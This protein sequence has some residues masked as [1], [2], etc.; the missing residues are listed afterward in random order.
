M[1]LPTERTVTG[2]YTNPVTGEPYDGTNGD[3]Y[4]IFEPVPARWTDKFGNQILVG[5]GKVTLEVDGTFAETLVCTDADGVEPEDGRLWKFRQFVA[6]VWRTEYFFLPTGDGTDVDITDILSVDIN[7]IPYV[8]V[9]GGEGPEGPAGPTGPQGPTGATG[10]QGPMGEPGTGDGLT[11]GIVTGGRIDIAVGNPSAITIQPFQ[12]HIVDIDTVPITVTEVTLSAPLTVALDGAALS[13]V[14]T[15]WLI[16]ANLNVYQQELRPEGGELRN[17]I[18][19]GVTAQASGTIILIKSVATLLPQVGNQLV[20]LMDAIG[21]FNILGNEITPNGANKFLNRAAGKVFSRG[22]GHYIG[23]TLTESP[24]TLPTVAETPAT[25]IHITRNTSILSAP[26]TATVDTANYDNNGTLTAIG[27]GANSSVV[28][29]LWLF[30][31]N[32]GG[33]FE[34]HALQYGQTVHPNLADAINAAGKGAYVTNTGLPGNGILLG[35]L[36]VKKNATNLSDP[37]QAN[38]IQAAK[39]GVG[40]GSS[41]DPLTLYAKLAGDTFTGAIGSSLG[42]ASS[43]AHFIQVAGDAFNRYRALADGTML[44]GPG[45]G[46]LDTELSR[47][48]SG[49]MGFVNTDL[50]IGQEAAKAIRVRQSGLDLDI[51]GAAGDLNLSVYELGGFT[52]TLFPYLQLENATQ[53]A[54]AIGRWEFTNAPSNPPVHTIDGASNLLG[55]HGATAIAKQEI[56]G[57]RSTGTALADLLTSLANLGLI[58]DSTTAGPG[59]FLQAANNLS[60]LTDVPTARTN[61]GLGTMATQ[62]MP[63]DIFDVTSYGAVGDGK[64][65]SDG[66]MTAGSATLTCASGPFLPGDVGK[67]VIVLNAGALNETFSGTI[68]AYVS[69]TQVTLS[70]I[71]GSTVSN[72][73]VLWAT[74]DTQEIQ[75]AVNAA[76][77]WAISNSYAATVRF[78]TTSGAFYGVAG[79]LDTSG[80][81]NSQIRLPVVPATGRK[82]TLTFEGERT[83]AGVQHWQQTEINASGAT[84]VSFG[85]FANSTAQLNSINANGNAAVIGGPSQPGGF[86]VAPGVFSNVYFDIGNM[87]ILTCHSK[88]GYTY[89]ALDLSGIANAQL[90]DF[91]YATSGTVAPPGASYQNPSVFASG[92]AVGVALPANGN[93]DNTIVRNVTCGGGYTYGMIATEHTDIFGLR[94]LYCWAALCPAGTY[95]GSVGAAHSIRGTLISIEVC[96]YLIYIFGQGSGGVGP[97]MY[98]HIDTETSTPRFGGTSSGSLAAARGEV[99]LAGLFT[100]SGL[101]LDNPT[102]L[103]I[104]NSQLTF[105]S[106]L[107]TANYTATSFDEVVLGDATSASITISLPTAVGRTDPITVKKV[108]FSQNFVTVD[109]FGSQ[110]IDGVLTVALRV[111]WE[112][113]TVVPHNGNWYTQAYVIT[114]GGGVTIA[115][116]TSTIPFTIAHRG[117]GGEFPEHTMAAYEGAVAAGAMAI[118][119]SVQVTADGVPVCYHDT[120]LMRMSGVPTEGVGDYTYAQLSQVIKVRAQAL[121]GD[122]WSDQPLPT[123]SDVLDR[124]VGKVVIF[125]E[126]KDNDSIPIL[127]D[128]LLGRYPGSQSSV[129]WKNY[130]LS[131]SFAWAKANGFTTWAYID[132]GTTSGQMDSVDANV[133]W[134]GVPL[135]ATDSKITEVVNRGKTVIVWSI[136]RHAD[137]ARV[138]GLGVEGLMEGEWIYLNNQRSM[139]GVQAWTKVKTPGTIGVVPYNADYALKYDSSQRMFITQIPNNAVLMGGHRVSTAQ[140]AGTY[141]IAF[142]MTWDTVPGTATLHSGIAFG[143]PDDTAYIFSGA[144]ASGG[145][146]VV[147]RANGDLQLFRH[148]AGVTTGTQLGSTVPTAAPVAG[149]PMTFEVTVT[150]TALSV[151][152]TDVGPYTVNS[153][154][155]TY[156][157]RYWHLSP[158]SVTDPATTPYFSNVY[159]F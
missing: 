43:I 36:A 139:P 6:G 7:D 131:G 22:W 133:D 124:F 34:T 1:P 17:F 138:T 98:L 27:G 89:S 121:L 42:D 94:I 31:T 127:Q 21:A 38:F 155:T 25:W 149:V 132:T 103:R 71:A 144:N 55:F 4:V 77:L 101:T 63:P 11:T 76:V 24:H 73:P 26:P 157:G 16:D 61:L 3:H 118:E 95:F 54:H 28:H 39:F 86:G 84:I 122:G 19:L 62:D 150:P 5:G 100:P 57:D 69:P 152:R 128:M 135:E 97:T 50:M 52:G 8:P 32:T 143:K 158:G 75:A 99:V 46:T 96:T 113:I 108:D 23:T 117:S 68:S 10:P 125:L 109:A 120:D 159:T 142:T 88:Y 74:D 12:G 105:P 129:V 14:P 102:G 59:G 151:S 44:W 65:A 51:Q 48:S 35:F 91:M 67:A 140:A 64:M 110:T 93:N 9:P 56:T 80:L 148:T 45:T 106:A 156:R 72:M 116:L 130:Y 18:V 29:R 70:A 13:R 92:L 141:T 137:V 33:G 154:D 41:S 145:Y 153:S 47:I 119:V 30:P 2:R 146:H 104:R 60:D 107:K 136:H 49:L 114:E 111:P 134:W 37:T 147:F 83:G 112:S 20:D 78:P 115:D 90:R 58:T 53:L 79:A 40:P 85:L 82:L 15:W 81:G 87:S 66:A 123:I 126:G